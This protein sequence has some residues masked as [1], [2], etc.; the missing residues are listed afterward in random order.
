MSQ[1]TRL[2]CS[3]DNG[4]VPFQGKKPQSSLGR[5]SAP[6]VRFAMRPIRRVKAN[7]SGVGGKK[8]V[9]GV[10]CRFRDL[11]NFRL[12]NFSFVEVS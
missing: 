4:S 3:V 7:D 5:E 8:S 10:L 12:D 9:L 6:A 11:L 1:C 2:Y